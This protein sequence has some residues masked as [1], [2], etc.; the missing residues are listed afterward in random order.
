MVEFWSKEDFSHEDAG[1]QSGETNGDAP[2][3]NPMPPP[4]NRTGHYYL[5][6]H[7]G[8]QVTKRQVAALS[9]DCRALWSTLLEQ[10]RA[11]AT[12]GK[13]SG[14]AWEFFSRMVLANPNHAF[15]RWCSDRQ[16]KL[17]EWAT[18]N[19]SSW[20]F[21]MGLRQKKTKKPKNEI[22]NDPA[23]FH[24][25]STERDSEVKDDNGKCKVDDDSM[26]VADNDGR[27]SDDSTRG[28]DNGNTQPQ[29]QPVCQ[30]HISAQY[31]IPHSRS[32]SYAHALVQR[33][34]SR[35][36]CKVS[37]T[38]CYLKLTPAS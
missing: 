32:R 33:R 6:H 36:H 26:D 11:P 13:M 20:A 25:S 9:Y 18:Q 21:N 3:D 28:D 2:T 22:L 31:G 12:F 15:L 17:R 30:T 7:D 27:S 34:S 29:T 4:P 19:Y 38:S 8:S 1:K 24:M 14:S 16:W 10:K 35:I 23:L 5:Q 37:V